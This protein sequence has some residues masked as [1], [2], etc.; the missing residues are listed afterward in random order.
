MTSTYAIHNTEPSSLFKN[1]K[2]SSLIA[3]PQFIFEIIS[4]HKISSIPIIY[5]NVPNSDNFRYKLLVR[6][7]KYISKFVVSNTES[8]RTLKKLLK[9]TSLKD[10]NSLEFDPY[11]CEE[12]CIKPLSKTL[13]KFRRIRNVNLTIRRVDEDNETNY[14]CP[15]L[16]RMLRMKRFYIEFPETIGIEEKGLINISKAIAKCHSMKTLG[17]KF[18]NVPSATCKSELYLSECHRRNPQIEELS[19]Y[20]SI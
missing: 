5:R 11:L 3:R 16:Y 2:H 10:I 20:C 14:L 4:S 15:F 13:K 18:I 19:M 1:L 7:H 12:S 8:P 9:S 6:G 17:H